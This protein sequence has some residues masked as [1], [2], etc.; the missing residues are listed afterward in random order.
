MSEF[1]I[2]LGQQLKQGSHHRVIHSVPRRRPRRG[3]TA[4]VPARAID[5]ARDGRCKCP[6]AFGRANQQ[7]THQNSTILGHKRSLCVRA[8]QGP[9]D[10][11]L[12]RRIKQ[13][14]SNEEEYE[15]SRYKP[16]LRT[17][18]EV[19]PSLSLTSGRSCA[20][21]GRTKSP[22]SSTLLLSR[23]SRT[24]PKSPPPHPI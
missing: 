5:A 22:A 20:H 9:G 14:R 15:L 17:V 1:L 24:T 10:K 4:A 7:G 2:T 8:L 13:K 6:R 19:C 12:K 23:T 21:G 11:D 16:L 18:I 3:P